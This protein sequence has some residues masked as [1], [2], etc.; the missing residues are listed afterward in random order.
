MGAWQFTLKD[1]PNGTITGVITL[2]KSD[3]NYSGT[4]ESSEGSASLRDIS[5]EN[6]NF[7]AIFYMADNNITISGKFDENTFEGVI[8]VQSETF[9]LQATR[10]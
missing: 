3:Q 1:T 10:Q 8:K 9:P 5:F 6:D 2:S 7:Q 4:I